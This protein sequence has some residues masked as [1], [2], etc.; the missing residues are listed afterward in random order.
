MC[1]TSAPWPKQPG[2]FTKDEAMAFAHE[3]RPLFPSFTFE[4]SEDHYYENTWEVIVWQI[5]Q[6]KKI[7]VF[8]LYKGE[9]W[10]EQLRIAEAIVHDVRQAELQAHCLDMAIAS[11]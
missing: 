6:G 8:V 1:K 10:A 3:Q 11:A 9:Q 7:C 2:T 5:I 4:T